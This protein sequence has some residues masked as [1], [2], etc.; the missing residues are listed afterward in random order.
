MA[1]RRTLFDDE[2]EQFRQSFRRWLAKEVRPHH[3]EWEAAGIVPREIFRAAGVEDR[4]TVIGQSFFDPLPP[5]A[6]LFGIPSRPDPPATLQL[7]EIDLIAD[8][9]MAKIVG[10]GPM[11]RAK[12]VEFWGSETDACKAFSK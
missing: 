1:M 11:D 6:D 3:L 5:G 2:H 8:F 7:R 4:V 12:C 10:K 9:M